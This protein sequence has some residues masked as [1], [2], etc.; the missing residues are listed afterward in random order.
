V[1]APQ[2]IGSLPGLREDLW[3]LLPGSNSARSEPTKP[4]TSYFVGYTVER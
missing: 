4:L 1:N 3:D 2:S